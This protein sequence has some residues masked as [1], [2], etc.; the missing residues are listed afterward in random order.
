MER[1]TLLV[2]LLVS[3]NFFVSLTEAQKAT[4]RCDP[5]LTNCSGICVDKTSN[6][7]NCGRCGSACNPPPTGA[8]SICSQGQCHWVCADGNQD[9]CLNRTS[10]L[11]ECVDLQTDKNHCGGCELECVEGTCCVPGQCTRICTSSTPSTSSTKPATKAE[12]VCPND[13]PTVCSG[14]CVDTTSDP[15]NCGKCG[16]QC[17]RATCVNGYCILDMKPPFARSERRS[18]N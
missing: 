17:D 3:C 8:A 18:R 9:V 4:E 5:G 16:L 15:S 2:L 7:Q 12:S 14:V 10:G 6:L 11:K 1:G 13:R